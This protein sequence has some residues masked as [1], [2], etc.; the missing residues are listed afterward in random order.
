[1]TLLSPTPLPQPRFDLPRWLDR[2]ILAAVLLATCV[3]MSL[4]VAD[5]DL[6]GHIT[7][8]RDALRDGLPATTTYSYVAEG[9][10]WINHVIIAEYALALGA[11]HLGGSGLLIVKALLGLAVVGLIL[12]RALKQGIGLIAACGTVLLVAVALGTHW[13]LRPQLFSY[14]GFTLLL[15]ILSAAFEGWDGRSTMPLGLVAR[16][17]GVE[18]ISTE[19]LTY[20]LAR[21]RLLWL[22]PLLMMVWTNSHGGFLAG[23][24]VYFAYLGLRGVE[25]IAHRGRAADG[26]LLRFGLMAAAALLATL[27][28]P[29]SFHFHTWLYHDLAVPRPEI[30]EWRAPDLT[31]PQS[32]PLVI[33]LGLWLA[34]LVLSRRKL[35]LVQQAILGLILWQSL[36]HVRHVAF[37]VI[38]F[39][40][41]MPVHIDSV[42]KRF[43]I[44]ARQPEAEATDSFSASLSP[45]MQKAFAF[46][47]LAAIAICGGQLAFR[48]ST[49]KV[50]RNTYPVS[51]FEYVAANKLTGKLVVTFNWAQYALAAFGPQSADE[52]GLLVQ[53]DGRCRTSYSQEMLD[54]HFDFILGDVGPDQRYRGPASGP[55]DPTRSLSQGRPDL[56]LITRSQEPSVQVMTSQQGQWVLLYQD[57][58]AQLW[59][60][61]SKYDDPQS[62]HFIPA[63]RRQITDQPQTGFACWPALPDYRPQPLRQIASRP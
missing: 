52:P 9:Y 34:C 50:D 32:I 3:A 17:R 26:L 61:S 44:G 51:A 15:A 7:Y 42:L 47:L 4:N 21:M 46:L 12:R 48:L 30:T 2:G 6:W 28:N 37:L 40:W 54:M 58:L 20:S 8:G 22:V 18:P 14:V 19:P 23:L 1:M 36:A 49:L 39:G 43:G 25:A 10:P 33:V 45:W 60:R 62:A 41:W 29:Y 38:A 59:G 27:V 57:G 63:E 11:D 53:I 5:P 16:L 56:V 13:S 55:F 31:D 35:D 24:C